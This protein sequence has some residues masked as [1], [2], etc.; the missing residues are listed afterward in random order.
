MAALT[1]DEATEVALRWA[2]RAYAISARTHSSLLIQSVHT[3]LLPVLEISL[4]SPQKPPPPGRRRHEVDKICFAVLRETLDVWRAL[5]CCPGFDGYENPRFWDKLVRQFLTDFGNHFEDDRDGD[6]QDEAAS[7]SRVTLKIIV[8]GIVGADNSNKQTVRDWMR[9]TCRELFQL[10]S[11]S[12]AAPPTTAYR[13]AMARLQPFIDEARFAKEAISVDL[14]L[15]AWQNGVATYADPELLEMY[16]AVIAEIAAKP[17]GFA[18]LLD[19][20]QTLCLQEVALVGLGVST[21]AELEA[22]NSVLTRIP[23]LIRYMSLPISLC[24]SPSAFGQVVT[25]VFQTRELLGAQASTPGKLEDL[26]NAITGMNQRR[27]ASIFSALPYTQSLQ[28]LRLFE[29]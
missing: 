24:L 28:S 27:F 15:R 7:P 19:A 22:V 16:S 1:E 18:S 29:D 2:A 14:I 10:S 4:G 21:Q 20:H 17:R 8:R 3:A 23:V 6:F 26:S 25:S 13:D 9:S 5:A 12:E 11:E